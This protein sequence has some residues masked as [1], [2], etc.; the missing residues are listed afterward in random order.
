VEYLARVPL[1]NE[2]LSI[3]P[4][5]DVELKLKSPW[6]NGTTHLLYSTEEFIEKL[7]ALIPPPRAHLVRWEV[8]IAPNSPVRIL[9]RYSLIG[10]GLRAK[11]RPYRRC[12]G[13]KARQEPFL[14]RDSHPYFA[15]QDPLI[16]LPSFLCFMRS[17]STVATPYLFMT[18]ATKPNH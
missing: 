10:A 13:L 17:L 4:N 1:S 15:I 9:E 8:V 5:G 11:Y 7:F 18:R 14:A 12:E 6:K 3:R 2:R 16:V